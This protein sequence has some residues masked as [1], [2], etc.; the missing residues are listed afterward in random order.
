MVALA[1]ASVASKAVQVE[2]RYSQNVQ[3]SCDTGAA[4]KVLEQGWEAH[5]RRDSATEVGALVRHSVA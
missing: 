3:A 4:A 5:H 2:T 1:W